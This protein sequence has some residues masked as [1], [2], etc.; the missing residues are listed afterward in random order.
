MEGKCEAD[1]NALRPLF[2]E[3][4]EQSEVLMRCIIVLLWWRRLLFKQVAHAQHCNPY[5]DQPDG[6]RHPRGHQ[7]NHQ[8]RRHKQ[9]AQPVAQRIEEGRETR[10]HALLLLARRNFI[11]ARL[12][13]AQLMT[14]AETTSAISRPKADSGAVVDQHAQR[15][16]RG[17]DENGIHRHAAFVDAEQRF[18]A[19]PC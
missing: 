10:D 8:H 11:C 6:N 14:V 9:Q 1:N 7:H 4:A 5:R 19:L 18:G 15:S 13:I 17:R 3:G 12:I 16:D 2:R